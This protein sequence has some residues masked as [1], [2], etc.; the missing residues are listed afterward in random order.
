[1]VERAFQLHLKQQTCHTVHALAH[2][3]EEKHHIFVLH[4]VA[5]E[6]VVVS[7]ATH[8]GENAQ[9][10]TNQNAFRLTGVVVGVG[11]GFHIW[12]LLAKEQ[13]A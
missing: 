2:I 13:F 12:H 5:V 1:M 4:K 9:V 6:E 11:R 7:R 10:T 3:F 8:L